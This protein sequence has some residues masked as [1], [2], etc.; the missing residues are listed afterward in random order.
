[1]AGFSSVGDSWA[2]PELAFDTNA[3]LTAHMVFAAAARKIRLVHASSAEIF[4]GSG[5]MTQTERTPISPT[6]PYGLSKAAAHLA[7][8]HGRR[9]LGGEMFNVIFYVG[10]SE[11]R[12]K[13]FVFRKIT[14]HPHACPSVECVSRFGWVTRPS[15]ATSFTRAT[16][17][18][19]RSCWLPAATSSQTTTCARPVW[20]TQSWTLRSPRATCLGSTTPR[21]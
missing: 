5:T 14:D 21:C 13:R 15:S 8:Q 10:E 2:S 1:M 9:S 11:R 6:S 20:V 12:S 4:A 17:Q 19:R 16:W 7:V 18:R 3:R